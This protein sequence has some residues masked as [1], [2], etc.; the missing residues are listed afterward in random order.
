MPATNPQRL[1]RLITIIATPAQLRSVPGP[2]QVSPR[3]MFVLSLGRLFQ[4]TAGSALL[5]DGLAVLVPNAG[6]FQGAWIYQRSM[7]N[8]SGA[9]VA[10][11]GTANVHLTVGGGFQYVLPAAT[12]GTNTTVY[13]DATNAA[14]GDEM[15][16]DRADLT[17][18]TY[19]VANNGA[20]PGTIKVLPASALSNL[21]VYFDGANWK[22]RRSSLS[23]P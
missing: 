19:T 4:W 7:P 20:A 8:A 14:A 10:L 12:L 9:A 22:H 13:L 1:A 6:G 3:Y 15:G 5:D 2:S 16:I 11:T 18:N 17:A 23:L 21:T